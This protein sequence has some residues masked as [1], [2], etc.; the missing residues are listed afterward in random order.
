MVIT[1]NP[2]KRVVCVASCNK[3]EQND[4]VVLTKG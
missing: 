4:Y 1:V 2:Y 3:I